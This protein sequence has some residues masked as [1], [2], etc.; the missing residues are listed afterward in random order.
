MPAINQY[1]QLKAADGSDN[2]NFTQ[3]GSSAVTRTVQDKL[4]DV[5]SIKDFGAIGDGVTDDTAAFQA[6]EAFSG[7]QVFVPAGNYATSL[8][9]Y[10]LLAKKYYGDGQVKLGGFYQA[11]TRSFITTQQPVPSTDRT[12]MF[13]NGFPKAHRVGYS[14]VGSGANPSPLPSTYQN[15]LEW[16]QDISVYDFAG[17]F[18]TDL[19]DHQLGRSGTAVQCLYFYHGGQGDGVGRRYY[20]EV[21]SNRSGATH[22]LANPALVVENGNLG[23][24]SASGTGAY[25]NHSEFV[26]SD[27]GYAVAA[28]D[29]VRNY[30]RTNSDST[31]YQVW[32]H[33]RPQSSGT[34][35]IDA[36]YS[37]FGL[38]KRGLDFTPSNFGTDKAA[39]VLKAGDRVYLN[40]SSTPD[41]LGAQWYATNLGTEYFG[42]S[43]ADQLIE[44]VRRGRR[45]F[46][47][48]AASVN[49]VNYLAVQARDSGQD[50]FLSA[51]GADINVGITYIAKGASGHTFR[52]NGFGPVQLFIQHTPSADR[53]VTISGSNGGAAFVGTN[54]GDLHLD[55]QSGVVRF[56][57]WTSNA[58]AA[59]N[60]Y[61]TIKDSSGNIRKLATIA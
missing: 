16:A 26:Y 13:D 54:T 10:D 40:A 45:C 15:F 39:I 53:F 48:D 51:Q 56:G 22:F 32:I 9:F 36:F 18:N 14:F 38:A 5:V 4:R 12:E 8:N 23:V 3:A 37:P 27:N 35:S 31:L 52:T 41:P 2:V 50:V 6:A 29:R 19:A 11:N 33:D 61:V 24:S 46:T 59:V 43:A 30:V 17:G 34:Q 1:P 42:F 49:S 7:T 57:T 25:L 28:I 58:D 21:Y 44:L 60:G 55:P 47:A 20:G